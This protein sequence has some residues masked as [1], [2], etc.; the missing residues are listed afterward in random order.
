VTGDPSLTKL[1]SGQQLWRLNQAGRLLVVDEAKPIAAT[2]AHA[3]V[4]ET[5]AGSSTPL[6]PTDEC[7]EL[8][9]DSA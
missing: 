2:T 7:L 8:D 1:A 6:D 3:L 5:L 9:Q 4:A